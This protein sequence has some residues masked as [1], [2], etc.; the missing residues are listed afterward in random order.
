MNALPKLLIL[1]ATIGPAA[2]VAQ[3]AEQIVRRAEQSFVG[4][5]IYSV[6]TMTVYR[7]GSARPAMEAESYTMSRDGSDY[8]LTIY[9]GPARMKGT[10]YLMIDNDLWVRFSST[11]RVRKLSSSA[12]KNSAGGT[13]FSYS[14]MGESGQGIARKYR[15][16]LEKEAVNVQGEACYQIGFTPKPGQE[17]TY[18]KL[19]AFI[20]RESF[21]YL[22]IDYLQSGAVIKSLTLS[23]YRGVGG[24]DY[25]FQLVM[26]SRT[27]PTRTE[28]LVELVEFDSPRVR[29]S[30]F[31]VSYLDKIQ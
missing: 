5:K 31:S 25:P 19:V 2:A 14:D 29:E 7:S 11:G 10:A 3:D 27:R 23:D 24:R 17:D 18:E 15:A 12:K 26:E 21:R 16:T 1:I 8:S 4:N 13:D 9:L 28:V 30:I 6:S 22:R 20:G